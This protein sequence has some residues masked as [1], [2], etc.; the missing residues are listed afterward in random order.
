[1]SANEKEK[2]I[3]NGINCYGEVFPTIKVKNQ[4]KNEKKIGKIFTTAVDLVAIS[5]AMFLEKIVECAACT[6]EKAPGR[7]SGNAAIV[8]TKENIQEAVD[9]NPEFDFL[10]VASMKAKNIPRYGSAGRKLQSNSTKKKRSRREVLSDNN[11]V[12]QSGISK[13]SRV[14]MKCIQSGTTIKNCTVGNS[15]LDVKELETADNEHLEDIVK[16]D[17]DYD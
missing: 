4:I 13:K 11:V 17:E 10:C 6:T 8:L 7:E 5:S 14:D 16:D 15:E 9:K 12:S 1:M 3:D 2:F